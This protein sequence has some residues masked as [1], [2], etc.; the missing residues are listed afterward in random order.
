MIR[1][2][3]VEGHERARR[4]LARAHGEGGIPAAM[5]FHGLRGVGK[6]RMAL[7]TAQLQLCDD[8][9]PEGPCGACRGCK[10]AL[11]V[12]HPDLHWFFPLP[13]PKGVSGDRLADALESDRIDELIQRRKEPLRP[14]VGDELRGLYLGVV[15]TIRRKARMQPTLGGDQVFILADAEL[16]VP[17]E[18][19]PEAANA[20][21]KLLEEPPGRT[22]FILTS[23]EPGRLLPTIRSRSVPL[24]LARLPDRRVADF[25]ARHTEADEET[26]RWAATLGQGA[27]GRALGFLPD[28]DE[29]GILEGERRKALEL[30]EAALAPGRAPGYALALDHSPAG[31]RKLVN[32]FGFVEEWLRDVSAVAAGAHDQ[33]LHRDLV[34]RLRSRVEA[35]G[36]EPGDAAG[37]LL[38]AEEARELARGNVNPQLIV[39]GLIR[40]LRGALRPRRVATIAPA[41][42]ASR[43]ER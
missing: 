33:V 20:L 38:A 4:S 37:A 15:Q 1:L 32:L 12:E 3:D 22:R 17:Q 25:L 41:G 16:M 13:R 21:L 27:I 40:D 36:V 7:W 30:V 29:P 24:H 5:L 8:P 2:H 9:G 18:S 42:P 11:G 14:S 28:G 26:T 31:A 35:A 34:D 43:G 39:S 10:L 23:S 6:Q 19:S